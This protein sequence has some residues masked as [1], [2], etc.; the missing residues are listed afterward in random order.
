MPEGLIKPQ[1]RPILQKHNDNE[2]ERFSTLGLAKGDN[3]RYS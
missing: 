1:F 3:R 2:N